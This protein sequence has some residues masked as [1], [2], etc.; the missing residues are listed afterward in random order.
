MIAF[1]YI[2][3]IS[4]TFFAAMDPDGMHLGSEKTAKI[5]IKN[6]FAD[7]KDVLGKKNVIKDFKKCDFGPIRRHLEEQKIVKRAISDDERR[8]NKENRNQT[9]FKF[10]FAIV[11]GHLE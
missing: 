2:F 11:D 8:A 6:F 4:A 1:Q 10:G 7:F 3:P 5:F 9:M